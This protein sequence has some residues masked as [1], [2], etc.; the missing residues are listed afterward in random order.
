VYETPEHPGLLRLDNTC[1]I[2]SANIKIYAF[3]T[4]FT[5]V[6]P[7]AVPVDINILR[8]IH[9]ITPA[10]T[11]GH[12]DSGYIPIRKKRMIQVVYSVPIRGKDIGQFL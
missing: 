12:F 4:L 3:R 5:I 10:V 2:H 7:A 1:F 11:D 9:H 8:L 6:T